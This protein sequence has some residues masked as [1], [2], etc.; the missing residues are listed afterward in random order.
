[1]GDTEGPAT[2]LSEGITAEDSGSAPV[3][4]KRLT[5]QE[6]RAKTREDLVDAAT[7]V[8]SRRGYHATSLD[9]IADAAGYTK[10]AV[11]SNF[12]SKDEL[13]LEV[14]ERHVQRILRRILEAVNEAPPRERLQV[15]FEQ[16]GSVMRDDTDYVLLSMEFRLYA[17]R[18]PEALE[19]LV[20]RDRTLL[21]TMSEM[22]AASFDDLGV[23]GK[24]EAVGVARAAWAVALGLGVQAATDPDG[25]PADLLDWSIRSILAGAGAP[26]QR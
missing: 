17:V 8:F 4:R 2:R 10:G 11:Y 16:V 26:L 9:E 1:M 23:E 3:R 13:F 22:I 7:T 15:M 12:G 6:R 21:R 19:R 25:V 24:Q 14:T 20:D 5:R 18:H